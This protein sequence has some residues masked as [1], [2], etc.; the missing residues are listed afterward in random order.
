M[1]SGEI[2][3]H[4]KVRRFKLGYQFYMVIQPNQQEETSRAVRPSVNKVLAGGLNI[5]LQSA[6]VEDENSNMASLRV[7]KFGP[8]FDKM[9]EYKMC[10]CSFRFI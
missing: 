2:V 6:Q 3:Q 9:Y 1:L 5:K 8:M 7:G 10:S 4:R